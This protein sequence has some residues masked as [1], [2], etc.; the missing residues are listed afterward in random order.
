LRRRE[1]LATESATLRSV[2]I[3]ERGELNPSDPFASGNYLQ[4]VP[5]VP[6]LAI[7]RIGSLDED[8]DSV[9]LEN[10]NFDGPGD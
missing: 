4:R 1:I 10:V 2:V 3:R 9:R 6:E 8:E 7:G 5:P